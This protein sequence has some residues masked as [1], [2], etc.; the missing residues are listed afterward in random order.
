M[1]KTDTSCPKSDVGFG[2]QVVGI[3]GN[4]ENFGPPHCA[5]PQSDLRI[6]LQEPVIVEKL[7][8]PGTWHG[9]THSLET[10]HRYSDATDPYGE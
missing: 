7:S 8:A 6:P 1:V 2:K 3:R 5:A 9:F 4:I 10:C